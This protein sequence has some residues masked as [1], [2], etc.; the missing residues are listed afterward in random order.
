MD[1]IGDEPVLWVNVKSLLDSGPYSEQ[2]MQAW[3]DTLTLACQ[4]YP[5]MRVYDWASIVKDNWFIADGI[6][7]TTPGYAWRA[8]DI[9]KALATAFPAKGKSSGCLVH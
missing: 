2:N 1:A 6:H 4:E 9:A 8:T 5:N 3:D 7:Y